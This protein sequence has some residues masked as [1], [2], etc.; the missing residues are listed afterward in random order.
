LGWIYLKKNRPDDAVQIF[1]RIVKRNPGVPTYRFHFGAALLQKGDK[2][3]ARRELES[4]RAGHPDQ[5]DEARIEG[6]LAKTL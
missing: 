1:S 2:T 6:L 4:A 3:G 5:A